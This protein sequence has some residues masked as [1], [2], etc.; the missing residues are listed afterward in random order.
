MNITA[1]TMSGY[2]FAL[3]IVE[4]VFNYRNFNSYG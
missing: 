1:H 2:A 3:G 4:T